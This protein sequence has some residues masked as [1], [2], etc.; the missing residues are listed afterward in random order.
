MV[1][2]IVFILALGV[3]LSLPISAQDDTT[4]TAP[5]TLRAEA[6]DLTQ[7]VLTEVASGFTYP[8][9]VTHAGDGSGRLFVVEQHGVI[10]LIEDGT[11]GASPFLDITDRV[12]GAVLRGYSEMGLLGLVFAPDYAESGVFYVNYVDKNQ[13]TV[14]SQFNVSADDPNVADPASEVVLFTLRQPF[15]NHNGGHMAFGPDGYLYISVGDGGAANDPLTTGQD[16]SDWYGSLLRISVDGSGAY[17]V[18][19]DNPS[20]ADDRFAPETWQYGLRNAWKFSFDRATGDLYVADVGQNLYEEVNFI[21]ADEG[22]GA[23]YGWS[24]FEGNDPFNATTAPEGMVEPFFVYPHSGGECSVT[25]GYVYRGEAIEAL[26]AVY[27]FG[28]FCTGRMWASWRDA[29][30]AWQTVDFLRA[31]FSVSGFGE[32]EAGELY[33]LD[34]QNGAVYRFDPAA[35]S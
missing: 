4:D 20:A 3:L 17:T 9:L 21:P 19:E 29:D 12:S 31:G 26:E 11:V 8:L 5:L 14:V 23:N 18:P 33:V 15:P 10:K 6:P 24:D 27:V 2:R 32:D 22:S 1:R 13:V 16:P 30:A 35:A 34:Y 28:D 7:A 25:G